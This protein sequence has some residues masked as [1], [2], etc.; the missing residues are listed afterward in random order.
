MLAKCF[1][2]RF[3]V[4]IESATKCFMCIEIIFFFI[5]II[6][7]LF[8]PKLHQK[9]GLVS[10]INL[11]SNRF[12]DIL[13]RSMLF[14]NM[15]EYVGMA[16]DLHSTCREQIFFQLFIGKLHTFSRYSNRHCCHS[17]CGFSVCALSHNLKFFTVGISRFCLQFC[18]LFVFSNTSSVH[19]FFS[20][21]L[22]LFRLSISSQRKQ[23]RFNSIRIIFRLSTY[24]Y[25]LSCVLK[26]SEQQQVKNCFFRFTLTH[27]N[28]V[29]CNLMQST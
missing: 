11:N 10:Q 2:Q 8:F 1:T 29:Y 17:V 7:N 4:H 5:R 21:F 28:H 25:N 9:N 26:N 13:K 14:N 6:E 16:V 24:F 3:C 18:C 15:S 12:I 19:I 22:L 20:N 23:E 27:V